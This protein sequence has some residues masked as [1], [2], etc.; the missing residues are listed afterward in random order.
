MES[1]LVHAHALAVVQLFGIIEHNDAIAHQDAHQ[2]HHAQDSRETELHAQDLEAGGRTKDAEAHRG[3][4][5]K[6]QRYAAEMENEDGKDDEYGN[7]YTADD[8]R[9]GMGVF[10]AHTAHT[11]LHAR[12]QAVCG[13]GTKGLSGEVVLV[14][15]TT[16][17][18]HDREGAEA[19]TAHNLVA[20]PYGLNVGNLTQGH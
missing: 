2:T 6:S 19:A 7:G 4:I 9:Q 13:D 8:H 20:S 15:A 12:W 18:G 16:R 10:F 5:D 17:L 14:F 1:S 11:E 3:Q